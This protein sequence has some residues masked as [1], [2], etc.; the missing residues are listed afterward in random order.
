MD[1]GPETVDTNRPS[2]CGVQGCLTLAV[3]IFIILLLA[4]L[5]IAVIRFSSPPQPRF[6]AATLDPA[7]PLSPTTPPSPMRLGAHG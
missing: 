5:Y 6:G 3:A 7:G 2:G 4:M 1:A